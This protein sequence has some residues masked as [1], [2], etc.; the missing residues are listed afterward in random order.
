MLPSAEARCW[1]SADRRSTRA[2]TV[3]IVVSD[4]E[5]E[6]LLEVVGEKIPLHP[7]FEPKDVAILKAGVALPY[8]KA[9]NRG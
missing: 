8:F 2:D 7:A 5:G 1:G 9:N 3:A 4:L 6:Q